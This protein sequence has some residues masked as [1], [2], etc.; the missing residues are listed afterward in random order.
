MGSAAGLAPW[1]LGACSPFPLLFLS[2][3]SPGSSSAAALPA[4]GSSS[5]C[6]CEDTN[7]GLWFHPLLCAA[8]VWPRGRRRG[9]L[10]QCCGTGATRGAGDTASCQAPLP[11]CQ[12]QL[13]GTGPT[14]CSVTALSVGHL[15]PPKPGIVLSST[16][17]G[18]RARGTKGNPGQA[19]SYLCCRQRW[20]PL[21]VFV[22]Q[23]SPWPA[24]S[25]GQWP[26]L[27]FPASPR[28]PPAALP[29]RRQAS[30]L[31]PLCKVMSGLQHHMPALV[32]S[33]GLGSSEPHGS[34]CVG[35]EQLAA[36]SG[37]WRG[38]FSCTGSSLPAVLAL[39]AQ[40]PTVLVVSA[41]HGLCPCSPGG[42]VCWHSTSQR[43]RWLF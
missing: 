22:H 24:A 37:R 28:L 3:P 20:S 26:C 16:K 29:P 14:S 35:V 21:C 18:S 40:C 12:P 41:R 43:L 31:D 8:F 34:T 38:R 17:L 32:R 5:L 25:C 33:L 13:Q 9:L 39:P 23:A 10:W 15:P 4:L 11:A 19:S 27:R 2:A 6:S 7:K 42:R 1:T 30:L 36:V